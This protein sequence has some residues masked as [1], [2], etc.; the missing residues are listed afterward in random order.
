[1]VI[2]WGQS[3]DLFFGNTY[4]CIGTMSHES[5]CF[6]NGQGAVK[7]G[8]MKGDHEWKTTKPMAWQSHEPTDPPMGVE[9]IEMRAMHEGLETHAHEKER[10]LE[11]ARPELEVGWN[12]RAIGHFGSAWEVVQSKDRDAIP[13]FMTWEALGLWSKNRHAVGFCLFSN[14]VFDESAKGVSRKTGIPGGEMK[15]IQFSV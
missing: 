6:L 12:A 13:L 7:I 5:G 14:E 10:E 2:S 11:S 4:I 9:H 1:M 3:V 8:T 15:D